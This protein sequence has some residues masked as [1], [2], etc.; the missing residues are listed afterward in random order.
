MSDILKCYDILK[1]DF[2]RAEGCS[3]YDLKGRCY[4]DFECWIWCTAFGYGHPR[5]DRAITDQLSKVMYH[6]T[7][8]LNGAVENAT[9]AVLDITGIGDGKCAFLSSGSEAVEFGVQTVLRITGRNCSITFV[10]SYLAAY[11]SAGGK[12]G[13]EIGWRGYLLPNLLKLTSQRKAILLHGLLWGLAHATL[14]YFGFNYGSD[15]WRA[16]WSG[17]LM[18]T[19]VCVVLD[20]VRLRDY[21]I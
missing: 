6:G 21:K 1:T 2:V 19:V 11:G 4:I 20:L 10:T 5:I 14:I 13:G 16:L 15:Y 12:I 17:I 9:L 7:R 8:Y 18:M 3:L